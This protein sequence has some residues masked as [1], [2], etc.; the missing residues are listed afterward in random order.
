M[1]IKNLKLFKGKSLTIKFKLITSFAIVII[2]ISAVALLT[3]YLFRNPIS[4]YD[5][6][7]DNTVT[8]NDMT[9]S[10]NYMVSQTTIY[11]RVRS[12]AI[13]QKYM[14]E[15]KKLRNNI[16]KLKNSTTLKAPKNQIND[17]VNE[18]NDVTLIANSIMTN[19]ST[20]PFDDVEKVKLKSE[21]VNKDI[22][23]LMLL[24]IGLNKDFRE[25]TRK[26]V[27]TVTI[28][29]TVLEIGIALICLI[30]AVLI[31]KNISNPVRNISNSANKIAEGHISSNEIEVKTHDELKTLSNSFNRMVFSLRDII[32]N[33]RG[34]SSKIQDYA[35]QL[36]AG[37]TESSAISQE[38]SSSIQHVADGA[39]KLSGIIF[40]I[41]RDIEN[42][43][44]ILE[45]IADKSSIASKSSQEAME[46]SDQ[47]NSSIKKIISQINNIN[48]SMLG[49]VD[50]SNILTDKSTEIGKIVDFISSIAE[51]TNLLAL[52]AAIEAARAGEQ[53]RGFAVVAEEIRKL[54]EGSAMSTKQITQIIKD[55]Q[56]QTVSLSE[57]MSKGILEIKSGV[58]VAEDSQQVFQKIRESTD[59]L[60]KYVRENNQSIGNIV[61]IS[62][63]IKGSSNNIVEI[64]KTFALS[65]EGVASAS[66]QL[67][68]GIEQNLAMANLLSQISKNLNL[69]V[70][71]FSLD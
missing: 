18:I 17:I 65:S 8:F 69:L 49:A 54:A 13:Q 35:L 55:V 36:N 16:Q 67:A 51:Q 30:I 26:L 19:K 47:G 48:I 45:S 9:K 20:S 10:I 50:I 23:D 58:S 38:I 61:G 28:F 27:G 15:A 66:E 6:I 31:S 14:E 24:E 40:D 46:I 1:N 25:S 63:N 62:Q 57:S 29:S 68:S 42:L 21:L 59:V 4:K 12:S 53:G 11:A 43:Y 32:S 5:S 2:S 71:R 22:K 60:N 7:L 52:N 41:N 56:R 3:S 70:E 39:N 34:E 44:G 33:V 37:T 64:S